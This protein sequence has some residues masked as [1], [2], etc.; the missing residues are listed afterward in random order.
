M[1]NQDFREFIQ[2]LNANGVRY[3]V[4]GGYAVAVHGH[5]ALAPSVCRPQISWFPIGSYNWDIPS[6]ALICWHSARSN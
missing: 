5:P 1:L 6:P 3:L 4:V 2:S